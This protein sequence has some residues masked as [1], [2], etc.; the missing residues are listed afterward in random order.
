MNTRLVAARIL[1]KILQDGASLT[2]ALDAALSAIESSKDRAFIQALCYGV[3][4]YFH[5]LD[6]ILAQLLD[7]PIKDNEIKAIALLGLYQLGFMRV[8]PHAAVSETMLAIR[9]KT[10]AKP[11]INA[12]LRLSL[13]HI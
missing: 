7:K 2:A 8:K 12:L 6:F 9:K 5:Q 13:I 10:W 3:L 4:R 1:V 11:L